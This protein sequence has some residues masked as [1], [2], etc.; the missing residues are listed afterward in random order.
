MWVIDMTAM[1]GSTYI[2]SLLLRLSKRG[3]GLFSCDVLPVFFS[4]FFQFY[5]MDCREVKVSSY[6]YPIMGISRG[7]YFVELSLRDRVSCVL[8]NDF[9]KLALEME[10]SS[11]FYLTM[12]S[13]IEPFENGYLLT[14]GITVY[15][16]LSGTYTMPSI[17][18]FYSS[19]TSCLLMQVAYTVFRDAND[20]VFLN[21]VRRLR[22][23]F[24]V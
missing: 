17:F 1:R 11:K 8:G 12:R 16:Q 18:Y 24:S 19:R 14:K 13:A 4:C 3:D 7:K 20:K 9:S 15:M 5:P 10:L 22:V 23:F 21:R 2:H 6:P